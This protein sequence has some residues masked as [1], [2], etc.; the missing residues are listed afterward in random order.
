MVNPLEILRRL[1]AAAVIATAAPA[2]GAQGLS[3]DILLPPGT[4]EGS[5]PNGLKYLLLPNSNPE[6]RTEFRLIWKVGSVQQD[7][8]QGGCAHFLEHIAFGGSKH[9]PK[10]GAVEYLE[11]LGM[12]YGVDINAYTGLDRTNYMFAVPSDGLKESAYSKPLS[13]IADWMQHLTINPARVETEKGIIL[14]ELRS[15]TLPDPFYYLKIGQGRFLSRMPLGEPDEISRMTAKTLSDYY[16]KW[17]IPS[18]GAIVVVGDID[19]V[20]LEKEI[21]RQFSKIPA[22]KPVKHIVYPLT[23]SPGRQIMVDLD[24]L[25]SRDEVELIIPHPT[26]VTRTIGDARRKE[27]MN[28]LTSLLRNRLQANRIPADISDAWYL[29]D[30][31]HFVIT[32]SNSRGWTVDSVFA[33]VANEF[34]SIL[35]YGFSTREIE[36]T[37]NKRAENLSE[38]LGNYRSSQSWCDDFADYFISG[39]RYI[40][41]DVQRHKL[42]L[43]VSQISSD[44]LCDMLRQ[45]I[46]SRDSTMLLAVRTTPKKGDNFSTAAVDSA[47]AAGWNRPTHAY[48]PPEKTENPEPVRAR[49]PE[50]LLATHTF[51]PSMIASVR[52]Y[53]E[54]KVR[55][56]RLANGITLLL[57][58]SGNDGSILYQSL[59]PG[60][61]A[62]I[63]AEKFANLSNAAI[64]MD[65][66]G[67]AKAPG[68]L[69]DYM[70]QNEM[71][72]AT[73]MEN[74]WHGHI[75]AF[76]RGNDR[77]FFNLVYE[78]ITDPEIRRQEFEGFRRE[79]LEENDTQEEHGSTL[80][81]ML[82]RDPSR[83]K[84]ERINQVLGLAL[85]EAAPE[86]SRKERAESLNID[87]IAAYYREIYSQTDDAVYILTGDFNPDSIT[88]SFAA[89]FSR[90]TPSDKPRYRKTSPLKLPTTRQVERF[91]SEDST[92]TDFDYVFYNTYTPNLRNSLI[93]KLMN[94]AMRNAAIAYMREL[95]AIVYSPWVGMDY[96]GRPRGFFYFDLSSSTANTNMPRVHQSVKEIIDRLRTTPLTDAELDAIKKSFLITKR[97]TLSD[98]NAPAWRTQLIS[99]TKNNESLEDFNNYE[100]VL[101]SISPEDVRDGFKNYINPDVYLLYYISAEDFNPDKK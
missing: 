20:S 72:L 28:I 52:E 65:M 89:V 91:E 1:L 23:Y 48:I 6:G 58:P 45:V 10:R 73:A 100:S 82:R 76:S 64:Y 75:G 78:K 5:L 87:S 93:M 34:H 86:M 43:A 29:S 81:K 41:D 35:D 31:N 77:E 50:P 101:A 17:Y 39:D 79:V 74:D 63:P 59:I 95:Q 49:T 88:E 12:K 21:K 42:G 98:S 70:Y 40:T 46:A 4:V 18:M 71:A 62:A 92:Q 11:S 47:W 26:I 94:A 84:S 99:L 44:E 67:I 22:G 96:E 68:N 9:F 38:P 85:D 60:G 7:D 25:R 83:R 56:V 37:R 14:E 19:P 54:L 61:Y 16:R 15:T 51:D 2:V 69:M 8:R 55:E 57:R 3:D 53:P 33:A 80:L 27:A 24:S 97:E 90:F 13:I 66:G 36:P 30:S 32:A